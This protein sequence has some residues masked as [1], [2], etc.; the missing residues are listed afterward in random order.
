MEKDWVKIY[1][2]AKLHEVEM[3]KGILFDRGIQSICLNNQDSFYKT[4]G[5]IELYVNRDNVILSKRIINN[6]IIE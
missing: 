4:V 2:S 5:E 6:S 3:L 1:S